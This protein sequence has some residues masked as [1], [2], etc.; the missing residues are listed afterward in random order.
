MS[1]KPSK[2][3]SL[4]PVKYNDIFNAYE[5][6][7]SLFWT[8]Y[9]VDLSQ[10]KIQ[11]EKLTENEQHFIKYVLAF[12]ASSDGIVNE[13]LL[14]NF[15]QEFDSQE[16]NAFYSIQMAIE[17]VHNHTYSLFIQELVKDDDEK[18][19]LFKAVD[20]IPAIKKKANWAQKWTDVSLPLEERLF[21]FAIVEGV[22][23]ASSFCAIYWLKSRGKMPGLC[24]ANELIARDETSHYEFA[25]LLYNKF[26]NKKV[27]Q[28]R[29]YQILKEAID[30]EKE[31]VCDSLPVELIGMNSK[32]MVEYLEY[33]ADRLLTLVG[34]DKLYNS[35]NP[36][37]FMTL[38]S[39]NRKTNFF[40]KRN[41]EYTKLTDNNAF[42]MSSD[43]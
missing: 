19:Q 1:I 2:Q 14:Q 29:I 26:Y 12:F 20:D 24:F 16:I 15:T 3:Y 40:E 39:I 7:M 27:S 34:Y 30:I 36:F 4:F 5:D 32:L 41:S 33:I 22:L 42:D 21:A 9:E 13:N 8:P 37:E 23:F 31:F 11:F 38:I 35:K 18:I 28:E 10:D 25:C 17:T 43:F 6:A